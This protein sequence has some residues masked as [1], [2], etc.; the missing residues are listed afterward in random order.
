MFEIFEQLFELGIKSTKS[1][2]ELTESE[3][4]SHSAQTV[5]FVLEKSNKN[6]LTKCA[7]NTYGTSLM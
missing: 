6:I 4:W 2:I 7:K 1:T 5:C 3:N